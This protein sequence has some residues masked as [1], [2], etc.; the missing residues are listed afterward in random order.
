MAR[1]GPR[2]LPVELFTVLLP[3]F[4]LVQNTHDRTQ[5]KQ[6]FPQVW[7]AVPGELP[8]INYNYRA[9]RLCGGPVFQEKG[10]LDV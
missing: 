9:L 10:R 6:R 8:L 7:E 2:P 1:L 5:F 3:I 4:D